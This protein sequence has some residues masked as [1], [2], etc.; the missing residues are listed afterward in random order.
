MAFLHSSGQVGSWIF[1]IT[2]DD[3][4]T[5]LTSETSLRV[6]SMTFGRPLMLDNP[7]SCPPPQMV[8]DEYLSTDSRADDGTQPANI[9]SRTA[10]F[11]NVFKL[12]DITAEILRFV[13]SPCACKLLP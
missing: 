8:D 4:C 11:V 9:P 6:L 3:S 2:R 13:E 5:A 7:P 1:H 12:S 10:Y